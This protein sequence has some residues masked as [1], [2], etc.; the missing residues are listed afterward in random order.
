MYISRLILNPRHRRVQREIAQ[1]Y[2][3]HR[4]VMRAFPPQLGAHE[5]VLF[6]LETDARTGAVLLL[7][8]SRGAPD[9]SWLSAP[10]HRHYLL[11]IDEPN[12]WVKPFNPRLTAG[13]IL[14]FR[15]QAN[16]TVKRNGKRCGLYREDEQ[17]GWL[18]R[19]G[20]QSGFR[21]L[22]VRI[23]QDEMVHG[24]LFRDDEE[25]RLNL[26]SVQFDGVLQVL[27][28]QKLLEGV[29]QGIGSGKGLGFGLLSLAPG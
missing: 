5:R 17:F 25:H 9:W 13:Q 1:R 18:Q 26:L 15:L 20:E 27:D 23:S 3:L 11:S 19:K 4:T 24:K 6:R 14:R 16:P 2:E 21:V 12:P 22:E 10:E 8:Q 29:Q 7:V 28:P